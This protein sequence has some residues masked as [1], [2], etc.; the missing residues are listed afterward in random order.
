MQNLQTGI[1]LR[2]VARCFN[3]KRQRFAKSRMEAKDISIASP[4]Y[5]TFDDCRQGYFHRCGRRVI[6]L[7]LIHRLELIHLVCSQGGGGFCVLFLLRLVQAGRDD[8]RGTIHTSSKELAGL[9]GSDE[10]RTKI[11]LG[12]VVVLESEIGK[13][14]ELQRTIFCAG[15]KGFAIRA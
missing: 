2:L 10:H 13:T 7:D 3:F 4:R 1:Q 6:G 8:R 5:G 14:P 9:W 11:R 12:F 15:E